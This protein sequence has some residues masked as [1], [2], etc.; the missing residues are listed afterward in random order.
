MK[1]MFKCLNANVRESLEKD[2]KVT[3]KTDYNTGR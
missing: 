1:E 3:G 2:I